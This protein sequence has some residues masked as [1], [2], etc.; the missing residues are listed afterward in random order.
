MVV[1]KKDYELKKKTILKWYEYVM[2]YPDQDIPEEI[3]E[4]IEEEIPEI[5][6]MAEKSEPVESKATHFWETAD[7]N[8][9]D[10]EIA[11]KYSS[12]VVDLATTGLSEDDQALVAD[13]MARF[14]QVKSAQANI[15][16]LFSAEENNPASEEDLVS[17]I[18]APKQDN[19]DDLIKKAYDTM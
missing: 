6:E 14:E 9:I 10:S 2:K 1:V 19:V 16:N 18:C 11:A 15:D 4:Q 7:G 17:S 3:K 12:E 5:A 8:D 13:I